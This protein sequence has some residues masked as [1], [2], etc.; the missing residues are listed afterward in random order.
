MTYQETLAYIYGL[1]RFG[2]KPG[3]E[4]IT[5]LLQTLDNPH[6]RTKTIHVA[7]TNGKGS[8]AAFISSIM[9]IAGYKIGLY[10]S[11]HLSRFTERIRINGKEIEEEEVVRL[12]ERVIAVAPASATFFEIVTAMAWLHFSRQGV[13]LA[14]ME[15]GM[16]GRFDATNAA[17]G[18]MSVITP[19][20]LDHCEYLG[21]TLMEIAFEKAGVVKPGRPL[22]TATQ[23]EEV[24]AVIRRRCKELSSPIFVGG[25]IQRAFDPKRPSRVGSLADPTSTFLVVESVD[26]LS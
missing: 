26:P 18:I 11:P 3:L 21:N 24:L 9:V 16:G 12:A 25:K 1:G 20:S 19:V 4:R 22:V 10:T 5:T 14:V 2:M 23:S 6:E 8:T 7:G 17:C 15:T 13:E